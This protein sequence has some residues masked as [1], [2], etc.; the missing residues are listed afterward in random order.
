MNWISRTTSKEKHEEG[1]N[2][3]H[4]YQGSRELGDD[5]MFINC[6]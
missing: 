3:L 6:V 2:K 4:P 1:K 5:G